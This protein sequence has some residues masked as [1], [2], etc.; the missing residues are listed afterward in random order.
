M[1]NQ[2]TYNE[3]QNHHAFNNDLNKTQKPFKRT[4]EKVL[5]WIGIVLHI[6]WIVALVGLVQL[7]Q[8]PEFQQEIEA[9]GQ[10]MSQLDYLG[11]SSFLLPLIP[12]LFAIVAVFIFKKNILAGI[13][14]ILAAVTGVFLSVSLIAGL[15]WLIAGIML[16]VRKPKRQDAMMYHDPNHSNGV[17]R[18]QTTTD[19]YVYGQETTKSVNDEQRV[20]RESDFKPETHHEERNGFEQN[21][22]DDSTDVKKDLNENKDDSEDRLR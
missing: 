3:Q 5:S 12:V 20:E 8:T 13:L 19:P 6:I 2:Y 10:D 14:L 17:N 1:T 16:I 18:Q 4:V 22:R 11:P 9:T 15:L 7:I 21:V